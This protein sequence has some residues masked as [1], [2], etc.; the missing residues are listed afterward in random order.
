[1][2]PSICASCFGSVTNS[3]ARCAGERNCSSAKIKTVQPKATSGKSS[4]RRATYVPIRPHHPALG[5]REQC[6][7]APHAGTALRALLLSLREAVR[8]LPPLIEHGVV[9]PPLHPRAHHD[10]S[11]PVDEVDGRDI[12]VR[13]L[14]EPEV[15]LLPLL[16]IGLP[17]GLLD[18]AV[19]FGILVPLGLGE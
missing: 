16:R 8:V 4:R 14:L 10:K 15:E 12:L 1:M 7:P 5:G 11:R 18:Q 9:V 13:D 19:R 2:I 6:S 17:G 3:A